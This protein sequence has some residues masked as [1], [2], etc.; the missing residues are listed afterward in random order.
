MWQ[1]CLLHSSLHFTLLKVLQNLLSDCAAAR[2]TLSLMEHKQNQNMGIPKLN[3]GP[4]KSL[5]GHMCHYSLKNQTDSGLF[6]LCFSCLQSAALSSDVRM[7]LQKVCLIIVPINELTVSSGIFLESVWF[8]CRNF[9][10]QKKGKKEK[11]N[12]CSTF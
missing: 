6:E 7:I 5:L 2:G 3:Q 4:K 8:C 12:P 9:F 10:K 11:S 1:L